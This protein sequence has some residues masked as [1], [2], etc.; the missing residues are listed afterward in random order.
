MNSKQDLLRNLPSVDE[1]LRDAELLALQEQ[2]A[3]GLVKTVVREVLDGFRRDLLAAPAGK[4]VLPDP[5]EIVRSVAEQVRRKSRPHFQRVINATG[6][7]VHTNLGRSLL[8]AEAVQQVAELAAH[9]SNLE[10]DLDEGRRGSRYSHVEE[11]LTELTGA[12]SAL[13]VNNNAAAVFLVLE[14][15]SKG[16][17]AVVS[18]GELVEI[19]GSFRI[20]DVMARSGA[21]MVE[22]GTTNKTH[23]K[24][25]VAVIN[26]RTALLLKVHTSNYRIIGFTQDVSLEELSRLG[27]EH[28]LPVV[29][30]LGSG[31]FIDFSKYGIIKEPTVQETIR[32]G[33]SIATFSGDKLLGGPQAGI[34]LGKREYVEQVKRN[35]L[36]RAFRIDKMTLAALEATLLLYRDPDKALKKIPTLAM[37]TVS[38]NV[39]SR[40]AAKLKNGLVRTLPAGSAEVEVRNGFSKVGGGALPEMDLPTRMVALTLRA[41]TSAASV[42]SR[43]RNLPLPVVCRVERDQ[44]L[45][46]V[47]TILDSEVEPVCE[48]FRSVL[49]ARQ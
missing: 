19:G 35:P 10:F 11:L 26:E 43:L 40:R 38:R 18:R 12:E 7:V 41:G 22:V 37:I 30:D 48:A 32:S 16:R 9:Y 14:T 44:V 2:V 36:N 46:D 27:A 33:A 15:L 6:V 34:V 21:I 20:P 39:L 13:V 28:G 49:N 29:N 31:C 45:L 42:E 17:E 5:A 25:Y 47:R 8:A 1:L 4:E 3:R 24:D 23:L